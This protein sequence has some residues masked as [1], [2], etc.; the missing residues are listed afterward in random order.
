MV[1]WGFYMALDELTSRKMG[2]RDLLRLH[3]G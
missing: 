1:A 3:K 2:L